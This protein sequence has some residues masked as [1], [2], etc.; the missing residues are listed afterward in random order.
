MNEKNLLKGNEYLTKEEVTLLREKFISEYSKSKG[1]N[2]KELSTIQM[3][4]I[5]NQKQYKTPSLIL[6]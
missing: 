3:L 2:S 1:W 4:E 6:G 5:V